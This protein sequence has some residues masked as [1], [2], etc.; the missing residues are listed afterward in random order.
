MVIGRC[1]K[2]VWVCFV[3]ILDFGMF[4]LFP[5]ELEDCCLCIMSAVCTQ[6]DYLFIRECFK[7]NFAIKL[8]NA[9][10]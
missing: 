4:C 7:I 2:L 3:L 1:K 10:R 9:N 5:I 8:L 6:T